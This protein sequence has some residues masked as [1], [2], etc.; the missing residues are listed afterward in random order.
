M[1]SIVVTPSPVGVGQTATV[2]VYGT[3]PCG[4]VQVNFGDGQ[5]PVIPISQLP[6]TVTHVWYAAGT[7]TLTA[8]GHGNCSGQISTTLPVQ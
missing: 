8:I 6:Y 5:A 7:Y 2:I 4:A 1:T 3:N